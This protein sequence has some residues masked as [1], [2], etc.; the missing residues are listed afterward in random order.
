MSVQ[1]TVIAWL[2]KR[3]ISVRSEYSLSVSPL[4]DA[5][6][7]FGP[8]AVGMTF[9]SPFEVRGEWSSHDIAKSLWVPQ[10]TRNERELQHE[11]SSS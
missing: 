9:L 8:A 6:V 3:S 7:T 4:T 11:T 10:L 5:A 2:F 1:Q